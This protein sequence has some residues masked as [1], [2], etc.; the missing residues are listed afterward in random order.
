M[1]ALTL[2]S[3]LP[4]TG[5]YEEDRRFHRILLQ[6]LLLGLVAGVI[7]PYIRIPQLDFDVA[8]ESPPR[9]VR[10]LA[11][12]AVP[13]PQPVPQ[14]TP[15]PVPVAPVVTAPV[16]PQTVPAQLPVAPVE[17]PRQ[18][19]ARSGVLAMSDVLA[20]LQGTTPKTGAIPGRE[21]VSVQA[22]TAAP[23]SSMLTANVTRGSKGIDAGVAHQSVLGAGGLPDREDTR[24]GTGGRAGKA[25][26]SGRIAA[27]PSG[28]V[29]SEEAIQEVLDRNKGALY[30]LYNRELRKDDSLQG[31]LVISITIA[32]TGKVTRCVVLS[33]ELEAASLEQQLVALIKRIDFGDKPGVPAVTTKIPIEFF[34]R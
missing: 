26:A 34:P 24:Q 28:M 13:V 12:Q 29:R 9:R 27:P 11:E 17:T 1:H 32:P 14:L 6:T 5:P 10:L 2:E 22:R 15:V 19:A 25:A 23:Q 18:K 4:W 20:E 30:T 7:T 8:E 31:K 3:G 33:S 16:K 21:N